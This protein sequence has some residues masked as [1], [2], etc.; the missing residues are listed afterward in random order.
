[1]APGAIFERFSWALGKPV[2]PGYFFE[3]VNAVVIPKPTKT[4]PAKYRWLF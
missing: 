4:R 3:P 2:Y 1:M